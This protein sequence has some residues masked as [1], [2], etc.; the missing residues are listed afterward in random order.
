MFQKASSHSCFT[1]VVIIFYSYNYAAV[2]WGRK[3]FPVLLRLSD[4]LQLRSLRS[5]QQSSSER[6]C[7][8]AGNR[9]QGGGVGQEGGG[10]CV[11]SVGLRTNI[12]GTALVTTAQHAELKPFLEIHTHLTQ[13]SKERKPLQN[14]LE[15]ALAEG[16]DAKTTRHYPHCYTYQ[17]GSLKC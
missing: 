11:N 9:S 5:G 17:C 12:A 15:R 16:F 2:T 6:N 1:F 14:S 7:W 4:D 8:D 10:G 13:H 3:L